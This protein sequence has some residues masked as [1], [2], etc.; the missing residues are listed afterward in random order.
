MFF[1]FLCHKPFSF[2]F[3]EFS[4][5]QLHSFMFGTLSLLYLHFITAAVYYHCDTIYE[6]VN[7]T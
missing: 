1:P 4:H 7:V 5:G 2:E 6:T 3:G